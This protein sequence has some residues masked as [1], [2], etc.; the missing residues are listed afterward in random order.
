[1]ELILI[2]ALGALVYAVVILV[3]NLTARQWGP[4]LT[5]AIAWLAGI[6]GVFMMAAA[7]FAGG[8]T[9]GNTTLDNLG[10]WPKVLLG[11]LVASLMS[12]LHEFKKAIDRADTAAVPD[13]FEPKAAAMKRTHLVLPE[14]I[15]TPEAVDAARHTV[16]SSRT[17]SDHG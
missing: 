16:V 6:G 12:L 8:I 9:I 7:Q 11:L 4:A 13:W 10:F 14:T 15:A 2:L 3:K 5:Q 17:T 1:M